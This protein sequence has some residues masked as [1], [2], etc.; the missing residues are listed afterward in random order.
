MLT[1]AKP[2]T[3]F[4]ANTPEQN[5]QTLADY[6]LDDILHQAKNIKN[7]NF[8]RFLEA[9]AEEVTREE[10]KL[11][12]LV[13]QYYPAVTTELITEWERA[14]AIPD[15][16]FTNPEKKDIE[17]RRLS[18]IAKLAKMNLTTPQD[19][20]DLAGFNFSNKH[21]IRSVSV[22]GSNVNGTGSAS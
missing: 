19:F 5:A 12:E 4:I 14:V 18:V 2:Q 6:L 21:S 22:A 20:I 8:R 3:S 15:E 10:E 16:C 7:K 17:F 11:E 1:L 13:N 9:L